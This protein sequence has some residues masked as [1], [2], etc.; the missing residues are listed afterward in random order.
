[1][2]VIHP[3]ISV[4]CIKGSVRFPIIHDTL[5]HV[6]LGFWGLEQMTHGVGFDGGTRT[7]LY[8]GRVLVGF[9]W[10]II[11]ICGNL[12][13]GMFGLLRLDLLFGWNVLGRSETGGDTSGLLWKGVFLW[14]C[15]LIRNDL[16]I[17]RLSSASIIYSFS[18]ISSSYFLFGVN[19][20]IHFR[21]V[22]HVNRKGMNHRICP[23]GTH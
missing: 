16:A 17:D 23:S 8:C 13:I 3:Y 19:G 18:M 14:G 2:Q 1:M 15:R 11:L 22:F 10:A 4:T 5:L 20:V 9:W 6:L 21:W 7:I 12:V